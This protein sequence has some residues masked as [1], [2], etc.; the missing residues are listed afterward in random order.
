MGDAMFTRIVI[1]VASVLDARRTC[2]AVLPHLDRENSTAHIVHVIEKTRGA[3]DKASVEQR[4]QY[5]DRIFDTTIETF[6]NRDFSAF[7]THLCYGSD[8]AETILE[9]CETVDA[10]A[11][12]FVTRNTSRWKRFL[13]GDTALQLITES[14]VPTIVLPN[15]EKDSAIDVE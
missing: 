10:T 2:T 11:V 9:T 5:A 13:T 6:V 3:P 4:E 1:P 15:P 14:Q 8:V 7:E 12:V